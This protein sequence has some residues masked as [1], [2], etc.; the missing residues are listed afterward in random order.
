MYL[1]SWLLT[2]IVVKTCLQSDISVSLSF[3][4]ILTF[5]NLTRNVGYLWSFYAEWV[6]IGHS[7][8]LIPKISL[9]FFSSRKFLPAKV[10][11]NKLRLF[12]RQKFLNRCCVSAWDIIWFFLLCYRLF[13]SKFND[14]MYEKKSIWKANAL[15]FSLSTT[16]NRLIRTSR[17]FEQIPKSLELGLIK[18]HDFF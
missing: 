9:L 4:K 2:E 14:L 6:V 5:W 17:Y 18:T 8:K 12:L 11:T 15:N 3:L 1:I 10:C 16:V 13:L 7:L